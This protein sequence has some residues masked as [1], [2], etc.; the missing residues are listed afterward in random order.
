MTQFC[1]QT[2]QDPINVGGQSVQNGFCLGV[3]DLLQTGRTTFN[4]GGGGVLLPTV[5]IHFPEK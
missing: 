5:T 1:T 4:G 3:T 2:A